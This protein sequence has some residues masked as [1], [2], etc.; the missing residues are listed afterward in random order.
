MP[1]RNKVGK[2]PFIFNS[3]AGAAGYELAQGRTRRTAHLV[4]QIK[5]PT[6]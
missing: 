3:L 6:E 2:A 5:L 4:A 1:D